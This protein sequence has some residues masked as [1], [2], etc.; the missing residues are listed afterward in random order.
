MMQQLF[1][2]PIKELPLEWSINKKNA[3]QNEL[4]CV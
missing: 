2:K 3:L 4:K 1:F